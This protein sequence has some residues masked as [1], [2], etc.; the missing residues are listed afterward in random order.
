ME[1][2]GPLRNLPKHDRYNSMYRRF[3]YFWGLGIEHE[4]YLLTSQSRTITTFEGAMKPERYSV[5]YYKNYKEEPLKAALADVIAAAG[6]SLRVPVIANCHSFTNC[7]LSGEHQTTY[8]KN[9]QPNPRYAGRTLF[10]WMCDQS[11]WLRD[12]YGKVFMW[13]GDTVEFMTQRF[14]RATVDEVLEELATGYRRFEEEMSR[15][16]REGTL[17]KYGPLRIAA[18][19]NEPWASHLTNLANVSMFNNGTIHINVTMPTRLGW[20]KTP[21][22]M[23]RFRHEHQQLARLIQWVEPLWLAVFGSGDPFRVHS[24]QYAARYAAGSQRMAVSRYIGVGTYDTET[25]PV[26]KILQVPRAVGQYP[27]YD[28]LHGRTDY[29]PLDVIG[30]DLNYYKHGSHG[31]ELRFFDQM[32]M[33]GLRVVMEHLVTLMDLVREGWAVPNPQKSVIWQRAAG[34]ALYDG[35]HWA[36]SLE[37]LGAIAAALRI[38][39]KPPCDLPSVDALQW[40]FTQ[41]E[42][43]RGWCWRHMCGG[44]RVGC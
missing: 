11:A 6:G 14:Y 2:Q 12:E 19:T 13:D 8:T 39:E 28:W 18:P 17:A 35:V 16:P 15:L 31:L 42:S 4:T 38:T 33:V 27:W 44:V 9:P 22:S 26:G 34:N 30:L 10:D 41:L 32:T 29:A 23:K 20:N 36:V 5:S 24:P 43:R 25:M 21:R 1:Q 3:G 40:L 37:E 7:D